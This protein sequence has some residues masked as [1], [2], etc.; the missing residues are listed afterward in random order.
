MASSK[1]NLRNTLHSAFSFIRSVESNR[2]TAALTLDHLIKQQIELIEGGSERNIVVQ[3]SQGTTQ[4]KKVSKLD[5]LESLK[6]DLE[7]VVQQVKDAGD[8]VET[9]TRLGIYEVDRQEYPDY[10]PSVTEGLE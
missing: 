1:P 2:A 5:R 6:K 8:D 3:D 10:Y 9:L 4:M 7:T